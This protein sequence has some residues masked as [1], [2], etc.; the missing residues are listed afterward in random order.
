[1]IIFQEFLSPMHFL[2]EN[3]K[4]E[5]ADENDEGNNLWYFKMLCIQL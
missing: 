1:M 4:A 2:S 5:S 3:G